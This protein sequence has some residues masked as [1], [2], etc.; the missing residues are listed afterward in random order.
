MDRAAHRRVRGRRVAEVPARQRGP[1]PRAWRG[2]DRSTPQRSRRSA[3]ASA[4]GWTST[5]PPRDRP[6]DFSTAHLVSA[7]PPSRSST[8][9]SGPSSTA[10]GPGS[11][12]CTTAAAPGSILAARSTAV[13]GRPPWRP[14]SSAE[15]Q[16][17]YGVSTKMLAIALQMV[18]PLLLEHGTDE[19]RLTHLPRIVRGRRGVV[20]AVLRAGRR[21]RPRQRAGRAPPRPR[22]GGRSRARRCGPPA[23]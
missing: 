11:T 15:E 22:A 1:R 12:S 8:S 16:S 13:T 5:R 18:P 14:S 6:E 3:R 10:R 21:V 23:R 7:R 4:T 20:P 2:H 19:Q 17:R 9:T